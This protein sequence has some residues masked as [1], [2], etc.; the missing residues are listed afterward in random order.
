MFTD[1]QTAASGRG[2]ALF[3]NQL[4]KREVR[5][6]LVDGPVYMKIFQ[7]LKAVGITEPDRSR[8]FRRALPSTTTTSKTTHQRADD[9][10]H[11]LRDS[12][13]A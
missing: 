5:G 12:V 9:G 11:G 6:G 10:R 4:L 7:S 3:A 8:P 2:P 13:G 1:F